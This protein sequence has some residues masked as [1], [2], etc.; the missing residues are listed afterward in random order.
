MNAILC[1]KDAVHSTCSLD[2]YT[3]SEPIP[4][5]KEMVDKISRPS[6]RHEMIARDA[7]YRA[8]RRGFA[9]G[10]ELDDWLAAEHDIDA[11]CGL[12]E[13]HPNWDLAERG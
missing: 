11:L 10:H 12:I 3:L 4:I 1:S 13:P 9:P 5:S 2:P 6:E 7:Y 8:Q